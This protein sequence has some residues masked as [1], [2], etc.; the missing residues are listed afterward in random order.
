MAQAFSKFYAACPVLTGDDEAVKVSR[1]GLVTVTLK[2][3]ELGL[4]LMGLRRARTNVKA[5]EPRENTESTD[6]VVL[7]QKPRVRFE[8]LCRSK[9]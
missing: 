2:Q 8:R 5:F 6:F 9:A 3:L 7:L 4:D 1:L